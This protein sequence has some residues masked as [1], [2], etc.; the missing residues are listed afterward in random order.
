MADRELAVFVKNL[1]NQIILQPYHRLSLKHLLLLHI[2]A[3]HFNW[4]LLSRRVVRFCASNQPIAAVHTSMRRWMTATY[5]NYYRWFNDIDA[6]DLLPVFLAVYR[7]HKDL[8]QL[9]ELCQKCDTI[10]VHAATYRKFFA[11]IIITHADIM[12]S[13]ATWQPES[14]HC[15]TNV[16]I[17]MGVTKCACANTKTLATCM[18]SKH[19]CYRRT[20]HFL[21]R[22]AAE[23]D[24]SAVDA[25]LSNIMLE[26]TNYDL[27]IMIASHLTTTQLMQDLI[28][29][30][31]NDQHTAALDAISNHV[32][33]FHM[34][35]RIF[36]NILRWNFRC[37]A[38]VLQVP[39]FYLVCGTCALFA[40]SV[41]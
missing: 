38:H 36:L 12:Q 39:A 18:T 33:G 21:K 10:R 16:A 28:I 14:P 24:Q 1:A 30:K 26:S 23:I 17:N 40:V 6:D 15:Y 8:Q 5:G 34:G 22:I 35:D 27:N 20:M 11:N 29:I 4:P 37:Q 9:Q 19:V 25:E 3:N 2:G 31:P 13:P 41:S 7:K 32:S